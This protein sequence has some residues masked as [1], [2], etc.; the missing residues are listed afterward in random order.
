MAQL[1]RLEDPKVGSQ[2][3]NSAVIIYSRNFDMS[4]ALHH[5]WLYQPLIHEEY[6]LEFNKATREKELH[7]LDV[8]KDEF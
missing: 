7:D 5:S 8:L 1:T 2:N 3:L 4:I 6:E